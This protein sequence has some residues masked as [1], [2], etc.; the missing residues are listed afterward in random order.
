MELAPPATNDQLR[1]GA[2]IIR[3]PL[4]TD[5]AAIHRIV[6]D[7][8]TLDTNSQYMYLLLCRDF[9]STCRIAEKNGELIGFVTAYIP[10]NQPH[11][12]FIWQIAVA[13]NH[14]GCGL[15]MRM[16]ADLLAG[17]PESQSFTIEATITASNIASQNLF[18]SLARRLDCEIRSGDGFNEGLFA[19]ET[20]ETERMFYIGPL[21]IGPDK[22]GLQKKEAKS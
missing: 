12:L 11:V 1:D 15:S 4:L 22:F 17:L 3:R 5:A 6:A 2:A 14:R 18:E 16:L 21:V 13:A 20:H 10:P 8:E 9:S 19:P 7:S